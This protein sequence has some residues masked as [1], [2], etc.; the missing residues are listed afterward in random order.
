M[1]KE[2]PEKEEILKEIEALMTYKPEHK[3]T[4][5]P[6]YLE[7]LEISDLE[8]IKKSLLDKVGKLSQKDIAWLVQ[9]K[10]FE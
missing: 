2:E 3:T 10:S 7:Y 5:N 4:I 9:F 6:N 8:S 1:K